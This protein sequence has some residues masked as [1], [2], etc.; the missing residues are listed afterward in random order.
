[1]AD[2]WISLHRKIEECWLWLDEPFSKG[3]AWVDLLLMANHH[4]KQISFNGKIITVSAGSRITS[5]LYLSE[6]WQW[7]RHKVSNFLNLL[8]KDKMITQKRDNKKTLIT[9]VN[10]EFY[11]CQVEEKDIKRTSKGHKQ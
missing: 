5:I 11:Q 8:E 1:M 3:Q 9:I 6:R 2:G 4:D 7:S 10:Y